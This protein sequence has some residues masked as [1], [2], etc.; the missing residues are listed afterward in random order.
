VDASSALTLSNPGWLIPAAAIAGAAAALL[1]WSYRRAFAGWPALGCKAAG[2]AL[3]ALCLL[4]PSW[5]THHARPGANLFVVLADNSRGMKLGDR[6][7]PRTRG[8]RLREVLTGEQPW[9]SRLGESFQVR[10]YLFD[11]RLRRTQDF[12]E[13]DFDGPATQLGAALRTIA[14]RHRGSPL[15]GVVLLSDGNAT[16]LG[17]QPSAGAAGGE[18]LDTAGLPPVYPVVIGGRDPQPDLALGAVTVTQTAFE[19]APVTIAADLDAVGQLGSTLRAELVDE[20]GKIVQTQALR[21]ARDDETL[22]VRFRL[23]PE[24]PGLSFYRLQVQGAGTSSSSGAREATLANNARLLLV[25]RPPGPYRV[26]Y[27][28]GRPNWDYKFLRRAVESDPA[29]QLVALLRVAPR[30][31]KFTFRGRD[32]ESGNPL[33]RG[34]AG[35]EP[36]EVERYDQP[37]MVRLGTRDADELAAGFP[38]TEEELYA[39]HAVIFDDVEAGFFSTDQLALVERFVSDRGG[40]FMM[41][42]GQESFREGQYERTPLAQVLPVYLDRMTAGSLPPGPLRLALTREGWLEAWAR[43]RDN[44]VAERARIERMSGFR[45]INRVRAAKPGATVLATVAAAGRDDDS[46]AAGNASPALVVQRF[47]SGRSAALTV[48]DVWRWALGREELQPDLAKFWRQTA[49]WLVTDVPERVAIQVERRSADSGQAV[50][51]RVRVR[52]RAF[53]PAEDVQVALEVTAP[54]GKISAFPA[55]PATA[56]GQGQGPG[57]AG[58]YEAAYLPRQTGGYRVNARVSERDGRP[59]GAAEAGW[60][61]DLDAEEHRSIRANPALLASIAH[62]TGGEMVA[63]AD[64]ESFARDLPRRGAPVTVARTRPLWDVW[65][66]LLAALAC[67]AAEWALRRRQGLA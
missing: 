35:R 43:L 15:A 31:P 18:T 13:L 46:A 21:V 7:S 45:V 57:E 63:A 66:V 22:T 65:W 48:G 5:T 11:A 9:L 56:Q 32:G 40:G 10:R 16:D 33:F 58:V 1:V 26:L 38:R 59:A 2:L 53:R 64:L 17:G 27:V 25:E 34:F 55:P 6:G 67:F 23:R 36:D 14:D 12:H 44:E 8:E 28:G 29:V 49:R 19:D 52:D 39:Y 51:L 61:L 24:R 4:E 20:Q 37:V 47:G 50:A 3:L 62:Q 30:E 42:G 54:D 41:M 60:V